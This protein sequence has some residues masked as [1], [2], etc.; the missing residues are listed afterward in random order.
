MIKT[1]RKHLTFL[2]ITAV[3]LIFTLVFSIL[4][5]ENI[6]A[7]QKTNTDFF[8]RIATSLTFTLENTSDCIK[9]LQ[10]VERNYKMFSIFMN[11]EQDILY[12]SSDIFEESI[13]HVIA[14]F[15]KEIEK[16]EVYD[17]TNT[18][19][20]FVGGSFH[21]FSSSGLSYIG[22]PCDI[23]TNDGALY[24]LYIVQEFNSPMMIFKQNFLFYALIW[25][26]VFAS[27]ILL[28]HFI[29]GKAVKPTELSIRSQKDFIAS[30]SHEL[31][32]PLA[33]ILSSAEAIRFC[34]MS[35]EQIK[36]QTNVIDSECLRMSKLIQDLLLLSSIDTKTWTLN[37]TDIDIDSLMIKLYEKFEP[38][39]NKHHLTLNL[40][41]GE[42]TFPTF[43]ADADRMNQLFSIFIDNAINYSSSDSEILLKVALV[44]NTL[45]FSIIDHGKGI[46]DRDKPFIYDRFYCADKSRTKKEHFGLG[47][48]I[49]KELVSIHHGTIALSD[50]VGGGCT[51]QISFPL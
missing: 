2:F 33:V 22:A 29:I 25:L 12:Q 35:P 34:D 43:K 3:M 17:L 46:S 23:V 40:D 14:S 28:A 39:C 27:I 36:N 7:E 51:F 15:Q 13:D 8:N 18:L 4:I 9:E 19:S 45:V 41:I 24:H 26:L 20:S 47:L 11:K 37:K 30:V 48:S 42:Q 44:K 5:H 6:N 16:E 1:L 31:K 21:F 10:N 49:A 32:S 50:T 38:L